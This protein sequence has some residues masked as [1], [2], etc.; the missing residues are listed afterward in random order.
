VHVHNKD[1]VVTTKSL[2]V[3]FKCEYECEW[4]MKKMREIAQI[5]GISAMYTSH[6]EEQGRV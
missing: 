4:L 5:C 1:H 3:T 2:S 6:I